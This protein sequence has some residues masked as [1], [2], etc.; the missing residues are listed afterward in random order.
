MRLFSKFLR[1]NQRMLSGLILS[2]FWIPRN[3][4]QKK[5]KLPSI[6]TYPTILVWYYTIQLVNTY[7]TAQR[8]GFAQK[9]ELERRRR[10]NMEARGKREAKRSASSLGYIIKFVEP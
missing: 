2:R 4:V 5:D 8:L 6:F 10:G 7:P 3:H 1:K 9:V